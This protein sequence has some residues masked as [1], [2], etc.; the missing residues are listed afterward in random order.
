MNNCIFCD[1]QVVGSSKTCYCNNKKILNYQEECIEQA[2]VERRTCKYK[3][4]IK[5]NSMQGANCAKDKPKC[6]QCGSEMKLDDID[7]NFKGCQNN[8]WTCE[9]CET[10]A[11]ERIRYGKAV[12]IEFDM[13]GDDL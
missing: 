13:G 11:F 6:P 2:K 10:S 8:Y 12:S 1:W 9:N 4:T 5:E 3:I 7:Y